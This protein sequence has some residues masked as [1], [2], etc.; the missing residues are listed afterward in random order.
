MASFPSKSLAL[1]CLSAVSLAAQDMA[2]LARTALEKQTSGD[3]AGAAAAYTELLKLDPN[4][5]ATHV[6]FGIVLVQLGR[7]D[8]AIRQYDEAGRL[9]PGDPRIALNR[10]LAYSKSGRVREAARRF[11]ALHAAAPGNRQVTLLLADARLQLNDNNSVVELLRPLAAAGDTDLG[12][13]YMLGLALLRTGHVDEG[14]L[15]LDRILKNGDTAEA[16]F[17]L[18]TRMFESGDYPASVRELAAAVKINGQLPQLQALYGRA[19]LVTGDAQGA[20]SAFEAELAANPGDFEANAGLGQILSAQQDFAN[21]IPRLNRASEIRPDSPEVQLALAQSL[22]GTHQF[23][24]ALPHAQAALRQNPQSTDAHEAMSA[25]QAGLGHTSDA[26][27]EHTLAVALLAKSEPSPH[28]GDAAPDFTLPSA[29]QS[30]MVKLSSFR[31]HKPIVL[32]F[33]SY[34]CPNLR[35]AADAL[36]KAYE[37]KGKQFA[38]VMVYIREAHTGTSWES[39]RNVREGVTATDATTAEERTAAATAC[40]RKLHLPFLTVTDT[41]DGS[42]E[43]SFNAWPSRAFLIDKS[44]HITYSSRLTSLDFHLAEFNHALEEV[45]R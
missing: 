26:R 2:S 25:I 38:F 22:A 37:Q 1:L 29:A 42:T 21:A 18:G 23:Q 44:G 6:N 12:L 17:L 39:T 33:G 36:R 13:A 43:R 45:S 7:F 30:S 9:L 19:L 34:S 16:H 31:G 24:D 15:Q 5:V 3:Y 20:R 35:S 10:A 40:S 28:R 14:Q 32:V 8:E 11:E 27:R 41:M 4:Q